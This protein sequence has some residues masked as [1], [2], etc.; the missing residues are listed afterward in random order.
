[1]KTTKEI[2]QWGVRSVSFWMTM[3]IA[4]GIIFVGAKFLISPNLGAT[5]F[6]I[7][8]SNTNDIAFGR[9]KGIRDIFSGLVLLPL[10]ILKMRRAAAW[11]FTAAIIIPATDCLIVFATNGPL[12]IQHLL[13][14][15][16]TAVYM[17]ITSFLLFRN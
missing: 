1:M 15:G 14:H 3:L 4:L 7:P 12:D 11:V 6:G 16:L 13:I 8:F 17:M 2:N 10:L 9:I 5:D